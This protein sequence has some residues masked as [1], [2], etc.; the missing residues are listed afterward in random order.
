MQAGF[1]DYNQS[2]L[3]PTDLMTSASE[4]S[5]WKCSEGYYSD[6]KIYC[7]VPNLPKGTYDP[8][9]QLNYNVDVALNG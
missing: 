7:K 8:D 4:T 1:D 9:G 5:N 6:G 2:A 3:D